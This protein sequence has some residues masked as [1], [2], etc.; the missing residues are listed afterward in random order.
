M[1][2]KYRYFIGGSQAIQF[3]PNGIG[4]WQ[5]Y[6]RGQRDDKRSSLS[7]KWFE[8]ASSKKEVKR[9]E[10]FNYIREISRKTN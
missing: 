10:F 1:K 6:N 7:L 3:W 2:S 4:Y 9:K 8:T 5:H